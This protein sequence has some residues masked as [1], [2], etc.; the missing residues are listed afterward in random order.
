LACPITEAAPQ[1][2]DLQAG[3]SA[4][5]QIDEWIKVLLNGFGM[6]DE[7]ADMMTGR[8]DGGLKPFAAWDGD[9]M[10]AAADLYVHRDVASLNATATLSTHRNRGAQTA[11][12]AARIKASAEAGCRW[13]VAE[14]GVAEPGTSNPS[15][16]NLK[17]AGL[18]PRYVRQNWVWRTPGGHP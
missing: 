12:I 15:L 13:L 5:N 8:L 7:L 16:D 10:V 9:E 18:R 1:P 17:R 6:P 3:P 4:P 14:T 2:S 11:L